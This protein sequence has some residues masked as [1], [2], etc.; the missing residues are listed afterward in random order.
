M[1]SSLLRSD[2]LVTGATGFIGRRLAET[3]VDSGARVRLLVRQPERL[4]PRLQRNCDVLA[5]SLDDPESLVRAVSEVKTVFHCAANVRT[6][7]SRA[8]Y[9][10]ANVAGVERLLDAIRLTNPALK[11]L[12]HLSSLDVYGFPAT[13]CDETCETTGGGFYYGETKRLGESLVRESGIP[14]TIIRPGNVIGPGSEFIRRIGTA[15]RSGIMLTIGRGRSH[16]GLVDIDNL[17]AYLTWAADAASAVDQTYNVRDEVDVTW[18]EFLASFRRMIDGR[19]IVVDL[20]FAAADALARS[21]ELLYLALRLRHEPLLHRLLVRIFGRTCGHSAE[22]IWRDSGIRPP[23][24]FNESL[25]RSV[26]WFRS[27]ADQP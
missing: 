16:A 23:V 19:G 8:A 4:D 25:A 2:I 6:W 17:V 12:V 5:G 13:A 1:S 24:G 3:L 21:F 27:G 15:L 26:E 18:A 7:D 11:R 10:E 22:K 14:Y 20:P 9:F